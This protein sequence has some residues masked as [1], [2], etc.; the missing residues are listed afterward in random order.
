MQIFHPD[1]FGGTWS[2]CPDPVDF[3]DVEQINLYE[4]TN[5]F[6]S[7]VAGRRVP[8]PNTREIDGSIRLTSEQRNHFELVNGTRGRSGEQLDIWSAVYGPL[9]DD[10]YFKPLFDKF[11]GEMDPEVADYWI[12]NYSLL[13]YLERNWPEVGPKLIGKIHVYTGTMDNFYLNNSTKILDEWMRTTTN[14][15]YAGYFEYGEGAGHCYVG[16]ASDWDR[17]REIAA[18]MMDRKPANAPDSWYR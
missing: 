11:T 12:D 3:H 14:P 16:Q 7:T 5:A 4:D 8:T 6:Y 9:G 2:Y 10:G 17:L 13:H 15:H 1:F 18:Y